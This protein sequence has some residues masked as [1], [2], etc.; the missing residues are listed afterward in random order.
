[1][2]EFGKEQERGETNDQEEFRESKGGGEREAI[3]GKAVV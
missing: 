1:M 3:K 2:W